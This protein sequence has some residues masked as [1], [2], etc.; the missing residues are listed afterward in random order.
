MFGRNQV[1]DRDLLKT[2]LQRLAR[3]GTSSASKVNVAVQQGNVTL[4]GTLQHAIQ[5]DSIIKAV[6]RVAGVRRVSDLLQHITKKRND[7]GHSLR[8]AEYKRVAEELVDSD[9]ASDVLA[10][11]DR[12]QPTD[13][14]VATIP[15]VPPRTE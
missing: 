9:A 11:D 13:M 10:A 4:T 15:L 6:S 14:P 5:R 12:H 1:S 3:T 7:D 2:I 8:A